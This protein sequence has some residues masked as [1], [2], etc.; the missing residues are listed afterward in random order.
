M[1]ALRP[2][3]PN[4]IRA[5][6]AGSRAGF[7]RR[8]RDL[9]RRLK[10]THKKHHMD[11]IEGLWREALGSRSCPG[12]RLRGHHCR[13]EDKRC[14]QF[15]DPCDGESSDDTP[16]RPGH[17]TCVVPSHA[18]RSRSPEVR[19]E[20][21]LSSKIPDLMEAAGRVPVSPGAADVDMQPAGA[22]SPAARGGA[23]QLSG[24]PED[25][26]GTEEQR[27]GAAGCMAAEPAVPGGHTRGRTRG[28]RLSPRLPPRLG[29]EDKA[30]KLLLSKRK[31]ELFL[32]EPEKRKRKKQHSAWAQ[33]INCA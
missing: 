15:S 17:V 8:W 22:S 23:A 12:A 28:S 32:A 16:G 2:R 31:L 30:P 10:V 11:L 21:A 29:S 7:R 5:A 3:R 33:G 27:R 24:A 25:W 26:R 19:V 1:A 4:C 13:K 9:P 6:F 20:D 14:P 18:P